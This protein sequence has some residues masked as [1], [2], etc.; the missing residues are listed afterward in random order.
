MFVTPVLT[1]HTLAMQVKEHEQEAAKL[2]AVFPCILR[3]LPTCVFNKKDPIVVGADVVEGIAKVCPGR[4]CCKELRQRRSGPVMCAPHPR[5]AS[6]VSMCTDEEGFQHLF[7][8]EN[9]LKTGPQLLR[10]IVNISTVSML[11]RLG[12]HCAYPLRA[13]WTLGA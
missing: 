6:T 8:R 4:I 3:I 11:R 10:E 12:R 13:V 5:M 2:D 7:R 1:R 9:L